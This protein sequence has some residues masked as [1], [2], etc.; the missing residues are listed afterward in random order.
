MAY[1]RRYYLKRIVEIQEVTLAE[2][3]QG[4]TLKW[5]Y[6]NKIKEAYHISYTTYSN[7]LGIPAKKQLEE[8]KNSTK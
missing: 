1:N 7:Y 2:Q 4:A 6:K 8:L 3:R 5:I